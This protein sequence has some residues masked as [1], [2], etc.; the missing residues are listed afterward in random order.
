MSMKALLA[1]AVTAAVIAVVPAAKAQEY[2]WRMATAVAENSYFYDAFVKRFVDYAKELTGGRV[3][4]TPYGAGVITPAFK[5]YDAVSDGI[6]ELGH[7]SP[8]YLLNVDPANGLL[9]AFPGGMTGDT[10]LH[11]LYD[12]GGKQLWEQFRESEMHLHPLI[13][14]LHGSEVFLHSR[15]PIRSAADLKGLKI[16]TGGPNGEVVRDYFGAIPV[17]AAQPEIYGLLERG[18][19]DA[20]EFATPAPNAAAGYNEIAR[21]VIVP[22]I[23]T[24]SSPWELVMTQERWE[25]LPADI[26]SDLEMAAQ[27]T[28]LNSYLQ[29]GVD[30]LAAMDAFRKN[31]NEIIQLDPA[32]IQAYRDA[33]RDWAKKKA[34]AQ[35]AKGNDWMEKIL[36][37]YVGFQ[38]RWIE[39][40]VYR[41]EDR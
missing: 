40:S 26:Q 16:R 31:K 5:V 39:D 36:A 34:E 27:L 12:G 29:T 9:A 23:H 21:Y 6:V 28:T 8:G 17:S 11:W 3:Q 13:V 37:S 10:M 15:K 18:A 19:I 22:G 32:L 24:P 35:K 14:G 33:G 25:S 38:E 1:T 41:V 2:Q 4:I 7:S 20:A 30:D